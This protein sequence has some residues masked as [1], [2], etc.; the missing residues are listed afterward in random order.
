MLVFNIIPAMGLIFRDMTNFTG[1]EYTYPIGKHHHI[2]PSQDADESL[3]D[4]QKEKKSNLM[5]IMTNLYDILKNPKDKN[6]CKCFLDGLHGNPFEFDHS[7]ESVID[8]LVHYISTNFFKNH[9]MYPDEDVHTENV[10][11]LH[12]LEDLREIP[13]TTTYVF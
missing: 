1:Y 9:Y 6:A 2:S 8:E 7:L 4:I 11:L 10:R 5:N 3:S 12:I 13:R